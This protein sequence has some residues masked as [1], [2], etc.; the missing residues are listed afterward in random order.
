MSEFIEIHKFFV[1]CLAGGVV[2]MWAG[3]LIFG[4]LQ[5]SRSERE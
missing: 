2:G 3:F 5:T 1:G 4:L